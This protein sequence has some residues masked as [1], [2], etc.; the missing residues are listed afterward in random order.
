MYIHF[1]PLSIFQYLENKNL[2]PP[3]QLPVPHPISAH[4]GLHQEELLGCLRHHGTEGGLASL[5]G[6]GHDGLGAQP[7][8]AKPFVILPLRQKWQWLGFSSF[9]HS[10]VILIDTQ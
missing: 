2:W 9:P 7:I 10:L 1:H 3:I 5:L 8:C 4:L 6:L